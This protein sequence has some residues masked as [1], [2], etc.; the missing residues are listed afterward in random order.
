MEAS[1]AR[2]DNNI[3]GKQQRWAEKIPQDSPV[4]FPLRWIL[5]GMD[6]GLKTE[7]PHPGI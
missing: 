3:V 5:F 4:I 2:L 6:D 7:K 1:L